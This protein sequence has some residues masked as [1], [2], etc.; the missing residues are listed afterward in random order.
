[1]FNVQIP[2]QQI[3]FYRL[4]FDY[5]PPVDAK[6]S[7]TEYSKKTGLATLISKLPRAVYFDIPALHL[8]SQ[9]RLIC[10]YDDDNIE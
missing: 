9:I 1:M 4:Y 5:S 3:V 6:F 8:I 10:I 2:L 7:I